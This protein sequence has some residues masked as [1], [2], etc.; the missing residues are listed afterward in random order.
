MK[1]TKILIWVV[2]ALVVILVIYVIGPQSQT[3]R[4]F[5]VS[6][7]G[8]IAF[9][10]DKLKDLPQGELRKRQDQLQT[11]IRDAQEDFRK[12]PESESPQQFDIEGTWGAN[13]GPLWQIF[14]RGNNITIQEESAGYGVTAVGSGVIAGQEINLDFMNAAYVTGKAHLR[15]SDDGKRII[16]TL[17]FANRMATNIE[18]FWIGQGRWRH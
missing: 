6:P 2:L 3:V 17:S 18:L 5:S 1:K 9:E 14:Q 16:G 12:I 13:G 15:V 7:Q 11:Q 4:K 10:F 8:G